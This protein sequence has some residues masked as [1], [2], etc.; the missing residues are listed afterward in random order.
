MKKYKSN[1]LNRDQTI[2]MSIGGGQLRRAH[3]RPGG[4]RH[5]RHAHQGRPARQLQDIMDCP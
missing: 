4:E 3:S 2:N 5:R 1:K